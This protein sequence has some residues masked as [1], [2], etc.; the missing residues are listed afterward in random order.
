MFMHIN[1]MSSCNNSSFIDFLAWEQRY[2]PLDGWPTM[3]SWNCPIGECRLL[4]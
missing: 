2:I 1:R 4:Q 3:G